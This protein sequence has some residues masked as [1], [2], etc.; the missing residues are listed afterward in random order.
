MALAARV[1]VGLF[2]TRKSQRLAAHFKTN[3]L[4][5]VPVDPE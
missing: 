3:T 2:L 5:A 4:A 1:L